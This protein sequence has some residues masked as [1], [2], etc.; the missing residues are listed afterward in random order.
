MDFGD[1][2]PV[3]QTTLCDFFFL[4]ISSASFA[5]RSHFLPL[6]EKVCVGDSNLPKR[7]R[8][9]CSCYVLL[10]WGSGDVRDM[11]PSATFLFVVFAFFVLRD[12]LF[13]TSP[14]CRQNTTKE[15]LTK[16]HG[17]AAGKELCD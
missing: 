3:F 9:V 4:L 12:R 7:V 1:F 5:L 17:S 16:R 8:Q 10:T 2:D 15:V 13:Q 6:H 11:V 14:V